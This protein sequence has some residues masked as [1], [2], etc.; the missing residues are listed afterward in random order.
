MMMIMILTV[1]CEISGSGWTS[2]AVQFKCFLLCFR[3]SYA[4]EDERL[5]VWP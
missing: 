4:L 5:S 3:S 2:D 1:M